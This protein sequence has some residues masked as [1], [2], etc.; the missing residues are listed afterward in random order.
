SLPGT[1]WGQFS[2]RVA[3][4]GSQMAWSA[5][6][7]EGGVTSANNSGLFKVTPG[8]IE[9]VVARKG[10]TL[11][12]STVFNTFVGESIST[13]GAV[14]YRA[15]LKG[16]AANEVLFHSSQGYYLKGTV[17]DASN[18]QV[19]VSRFLKFWPAAGGKWFFL[20]K[21]TGR[22]VNSSNDCA[23]YLVD[24]GGAYL[25]LRE[26]DYVAGCDGPK[27][28][29]IQRVDVEPTGG[30]YVVLTSL[31][32]SSAANQAVFTGDAAAGNDTDKR[33]LRLPVLKLR[34]GTSYQAPTGST[35]KILSLSMTNTN[36]AAGAGAK[37][38][39]QVIDAN[40]NVVICVQ[41][42]DKSKHL[43]K[44]KP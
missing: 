7:L 36:D 6:L 19:S 43:M 26:G 41:F 27:V 24:T 15:T 42:T 28:G 11:F 17:L 22:G 38:G 5:Y 2:P 40:G 34:K 25:L 9:S 18:P 23:L 37:G 21:L 14:L 1:A 44:G 33:A 16:S 30:Q 8:N 3:K 10:D 20:A 12:G 32:G 13:D 31:T 29:V 35:T 39:P 4:T